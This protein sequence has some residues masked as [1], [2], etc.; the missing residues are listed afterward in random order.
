[1]PEQ[2]NLIMAIVLSVT[3][4]IA[5]QYF[6]ELPRIKDAQQQETVRTEQAVE[7]G[8]QVLPRS[9][10][11]APSPPGATGPAQAPQTS[12]SEIIEGADRV[13]ID[14]GRV[15]G[16]F[17]LTGARID[18]LILSDYKLTTAPRLRDDKHWEFPSGARH[19]MRELW[20][21]ERDAIFGDLFRKLERYG[22]AG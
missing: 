19:E 2:R 20:G 3:I 17:A 8:G 16:S 21:V 13:E 10:T 11:I 6:Y 22:A 14:N 18:N 1:M 4:I 9:A 15:R 5:F 7:E 12:P